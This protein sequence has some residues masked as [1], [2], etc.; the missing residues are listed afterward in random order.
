M[1]QKI[2]FTTVFFTIALASLFFINHVEA[3]AVGLRGI[4]PANPTASTGPGASWFIYELEPGETIEDA[5]LITNQSDEDYN[6]EIYAVDAETTTDG[7]FAPLKKNYEHT[8]VGSWVTLSTDKVVIPA[9]S[10]VE[11]PFTVTVPETDVDVGEHFGAI[12]IQEIKENETQGTGTGVEIVTRV[13]VRMYVTIPGEIRRGLDI[14]EFRYGL[15][16]RLVYQ[17]E[18]IPL[19]RFLDFLGLKPSVRFFMKFHNTGNVRVEPYITLKI[20]NLFGRTI[21]E[22][23]EQYGGIV[24]PGR[25]NEV[26][27]N[28]TDPP[29]IGK[30]NVEATVRFEGGE[31]QT[32]TTTV[33]IIPYPLIILLAL[34]IVL[35]II[36]RL[37]FHL[38]VAK[39]KD[40]MKV[41][42]VQEGET[43]EKI[44]EIYSVNWK[45]LVRI[46]KLKPPYQ[47]KVGQE[48][49]IPKQN[50]WISFIKSFFSNKKNIIILAIVL[51]V[52]GGAI[53]YYYWDKHREE[54]RLMEEAAEAD[55]QRQ[56]DLEVVLGERTA[57]DQQRKD[58]LKTIQ[59]A[60]A[61][62]YEAE[63]RYP[64]ANE[65]RS[66]TTDETSIFTELVEKGHLSKVPLD[67][68]HPNYYYGY[69]S[70]AEGTEYELTC[71]LENKTDDEGIRID[72]FVFYRLR[73]LGHSAE[74]EDQQEA[75]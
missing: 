62:Y 22:S 39:E 51:L 5:A 35:I 54:I 67:P 2:L 24:M 44:A 34:I 69:F 16:S 42:I 23:E 10:E 21:Y 49:L 28:W 15:I 29:F 14:E 65:E 9:K 46:N 66:K 63:E 68:K 72:D 71:V 36:G 13:G 26:P 38:I 60:L 53:G 31:T 1:K 50:I 57:T 17:K 52:I 45:Y 25:T 74:D 59:E 40:K 47:L 11:V 32:V 18:I 73:S 41:H 70:D 7:A 33:W 4:S 6:V 61:R 12:V 19:D 30:F 64:I 56:Q 20:K 37:L 55:K 48:L 8:D 75:Q 27:L 3:I 43:V 58:D